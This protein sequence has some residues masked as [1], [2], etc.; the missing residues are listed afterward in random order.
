MSK[1][2]PLMVIVYAQVQL[3]ALALNADGLS[4]GTVQ[5]PTA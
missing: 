1:V 5:L 4:Y 2:A 3:I